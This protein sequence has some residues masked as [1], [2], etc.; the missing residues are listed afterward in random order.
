MNSQE[1]Q[2]V[3]DDVFQESE[4]HTLLMKRQ[5]GN[6]RANTAHISALI[7][8]QKSCIVDHYAKLRQQRDNARVS[9]V[10]DEME[11]LTESANGRP[12]IAAK[13]STLG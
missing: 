5:F 4:L 9:H 12:S 2:A 11:K 10:H 3:R 6:L 1:Q 8:R 13:V 7:T